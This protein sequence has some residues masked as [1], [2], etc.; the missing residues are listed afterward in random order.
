[1]APGSTN[2]STALR[3]IVRNEFAKNRHVQEEAQIQALQAN[4]V[5][6]LSNYLLFQNA[7]ADPKVKQA[8]NN[9]HE[10][11]S[12]GLDYFRLVN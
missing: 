3:Q 11:H 2:K 9:F 10:K 8:V 6:A 1:M 7:S 4:A 5:R 12:K